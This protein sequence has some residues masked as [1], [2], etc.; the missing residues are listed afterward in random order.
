MDIGNFLHGLI[1]LNI[2]TSGSL[3]GKAHTYQLVK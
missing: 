3:G 1:P 2:S